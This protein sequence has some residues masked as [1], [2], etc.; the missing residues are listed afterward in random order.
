[1]YKFILMTLV[2]GSLLGC[3]SKRYG[4]FSEAPSRYD[5]K[6]ATDTVHQLRFLYP[7]AATQFNFLQ[8]TDDPFGNALIAELRDSGYAIS[9]FK[10]RQ[11]NS[12]HSKKGNT[13]G[14]V[15]DQL[16]TNL[17]RVTLTIEDKTLSRAY[18]TQ[19]NLLYP[20][21]SWIYKE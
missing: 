19:H 4:N 2:L 15:V 20:A 14:Y 6:M 18:T 13:L 10:K 8:K 11:K 16:M 1:M 12:E 5:Q 9:E 17:Y 3:A 21:G 7:P